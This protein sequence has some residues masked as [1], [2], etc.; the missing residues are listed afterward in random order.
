MSL[1]ERPRTIG[2]WGAI[3]SGIKMPMLVIEVDTE[4][5][6]TLLTSKAKEPLIVGK[7]LIMHL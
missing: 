1:D 2:P 3:L 7:M 6:G 4:E 5:V